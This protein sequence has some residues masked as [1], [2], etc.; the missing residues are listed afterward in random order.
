MS[1]TRKKKIAR[2]TIAV[3]LVV[4]DHLRRRCP[5]RR[6]DVIS[7]GGEVRGSRSG[8]GNALQRYGLPSS[9][10]KEVTTRQAHQDGQ[11]LLDR[12]DWGARFAELPS[13]AREKLLGDLAEVLVVKAREQLSREHLRLP[14]DRR[15]S[16]NTWVS[17]IIEAAAERSTGVVEQHLVGAKLA[18]RFPTA[19]VAN[20]PAHAADRQTGRGGDF[21]VAQ[22]VYH[23]SAAPSRAVMG[24]C[25]GNISSGLHPI[26]LVPGHQ[27][28][29]ARVLAEDEGLARQLTI[30][31]IECF[32]ALNVIE[33][34]TAES[35]DFF[36]VLQ[37]IVAIYNERLRE[38]ET[39]LSLQIELH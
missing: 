4:L 22:V 12:L 33:L 7:E 19:D 37:E 2:N 18:R 28:N 6:E 17:L 20:H 1:C 34:A 5:A 39:D 10:L 26:L 9:Y 23:V 27:E 24:R 29:R 32:V 8:L 35:K 3:G 14:V 16:P 31:P 30:I 25:A 21:T 13:A 11:I 36:A 38:V 15:E